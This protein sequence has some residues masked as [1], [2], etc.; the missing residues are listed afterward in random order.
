ML[1]YKSI[2]HSLYDYRRGE[3]IQHHNKNLYHDVLN[4]LQRNQ[5]SKITYTCAKETHD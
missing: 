1:I 3:D 2:Y 4:N 5:H